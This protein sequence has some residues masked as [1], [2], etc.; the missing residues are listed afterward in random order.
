MANWFRHPAVQLADQNGNPLITSNGYVPTADSDKRAPSR[1][2]GGRLLFK[3]DFRAVQPGVW[4]DAL[5]SAARD[6][7]QMFGGLPTLR[8][9]PQGQVNSGA[10]NPGRT[11][12]T[13]GVVVKRRL[14]DGFRHK[15]GLEGWFRFSSTNL[16]S[17][18]FLSMSIYNRD[19][20]NAYHGRV[21]LDPNGNNQPLV[22]RILDGTA[23]G[24]A[25]GTNPASAATYT[26]V[27]TTANQYAAGTHL[28]NPAGGQLDRAGGWHYVKMVVDMVNKTYVSIQIDGE[29]PVDISSYTLDITTS[30]GAAMLHYSWEF[31]ASTS[32]RPRF[33]NLAN[34]AGTIED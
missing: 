5:G 33:V 6:I 32:T 17:N 14:I 31:S 22:A 8:L 12:S 24:I 7:D 25:S 16:T 19:G 15:V 18:A 26:A 23:T 1:T 20:T 30:T 2:S 10:T 11:A 34:L 9:D 3:E 21:W 13:S 29:A 4:N 28:Y 27:V